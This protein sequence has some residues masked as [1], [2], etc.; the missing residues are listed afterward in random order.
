MSYHDNI[1]MIMLIMKYLSTCM[2]GNTCCDNSTRC[3][4]EESL[5]NLKRGQKVNRGMRPAMLS[6]LHKSPRTDLRAE[7]QRS[8]Q[9]EEVLMPDEEL[10]EFGLFYHS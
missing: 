2:V 3:E 6:H 5:G 1:K 10:I 9:E 8:D 7:H 4:V